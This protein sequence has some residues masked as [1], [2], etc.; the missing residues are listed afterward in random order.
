MVS[1]SFNPN[2]IADYALRWQ[3]ETL[4]SCL[5]GRGF[6]LEDTRL[7]NPHR[8]KKLIAVL[9]VGFC[10]CYLTGEWQHDEVK[11]IKTKNHGRLSMSLFRCGLDYVQMAIQQLICHSMKA[12]FCKILNI[13]RREPIHISRQS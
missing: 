2:A 11:P 12:N 3:I 5:K 1:P 13:L 7:T 10:W 6:N 4:F 8:V 9:A